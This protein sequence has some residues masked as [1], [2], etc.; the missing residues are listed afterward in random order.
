M[1]HIICIISHGPY[2][3]VY[4]K[5]LYDMIKRIGHLEDV[6]LSSVMD[7]VTGRKLEIITYSYTV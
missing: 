2:D 7:V 1:S 5:R 6:Y 3:M 4:I